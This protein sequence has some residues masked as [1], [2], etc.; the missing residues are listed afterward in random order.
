MGDYV[1]MIPEVERD[2]QGI[3]EVLV[4]YQS[5]TPGYRK[6]WPRHVYS[7]VQEETKAKRKAEMIEAL[8]V[9]YKSTDEYRQRQR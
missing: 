2:L 6:D 9:G 1:T 3:S 5:F 4:I 7:A 8:H